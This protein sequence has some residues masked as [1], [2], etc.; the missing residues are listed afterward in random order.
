M[1][2]ECSAN[3]LAPFHPPW[4]F[5]C[6]AAALAAECAGDVDSASSISSSVHVKYGWPPLQQLRLAD[7]VFHWKEKGR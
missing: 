4:C 2:Y 7:R 3:G 5:C 6:A 1:L